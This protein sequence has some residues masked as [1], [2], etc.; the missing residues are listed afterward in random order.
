M[1]GRV[2][3]E[4]VERVWHLAGEAVVEHAAE[5][6]DICSCA[7]CA[8][9]GTVELFRSR[10]VIAAHKE[11]GLGEPGTGPAKILYEPKIG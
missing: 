11:T 6:V 5:R 10:I 2:R 8:E 1:C 4:S 9:A 3:P 7:Y